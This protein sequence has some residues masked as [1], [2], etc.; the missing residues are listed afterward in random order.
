MSDRTDLND[1]DDDAKDLDK[2]DADATDT[3]DNDSDDSDNNEQFD[4]ERARKK[5]AKANREAQNL[6]TRM[7]ELEAGQAE[8]QKWK[9]SQKSEAEKIAERAAA[10]EEKAEKL[11]REVWIAKVIAKHGLS[12]NQ[13]KRLQGSTLEELDADAAELAE[14][15]KVPAG[16]KPAGGLKGGNQPNDNNKNFDAAEMARKIRSSY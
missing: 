11:Q 15:L 1:N 4:P 12:E 7:K 2:T 10:A 13:A 5:I 8:Y 6:R 3:D 14:D 16:R 9:D